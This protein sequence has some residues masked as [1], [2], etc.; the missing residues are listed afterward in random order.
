MA[1]SLSASLA[2]RPAGVWR[3]DRIATSGLGTLPSQ[4]AA[5][6]AELPGGGWPIGALTELMAPAAGCGELRLLAPA[7]QGL[8]HAG[9]SVLLLAPPQ[10]PYAPAL[11]ALGIDLKQVILVGPLAAGDQLWA[12][13]QALR[14]A[15]FGAL[16]A[17]L[18]HPATRPEHLRR[19]QLAA[20]GAHGPAFLFRP[21]AVGAQASPAA[22]RL[23]LQP[24]PE[25]RLAVEVLKRR[26]PVLSAPVIIDL[27]MPP[28]TVRPSRKLTPRASAE[29]SPAALTPGPVRLGAAHL[30]L[31]GIP[32]TAAADPAALR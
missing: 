17:W 22:L 16:L 1:Q 12:V 13:E 31:P 7:L 26:G 4:F 3:A 21:P 18:P 28:Q 5:L 10:V 29:I 15:H 24:Q 30:R 2:G 11:S 14:S 9:R 20:Q 23:R 27:P 19:M 6:D 32:D 8:T 25:Q